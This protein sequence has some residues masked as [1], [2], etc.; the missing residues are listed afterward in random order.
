MLSQLRKDHLE[1]TAWMQALR[2]M[3]NGFEPMPDAPRAVRTCLEGLANLAASLEEHTALE[4]GVLF[5]RCKG[6]DA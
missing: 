2:E 4:D 3:T 5:V 6:G 1:E